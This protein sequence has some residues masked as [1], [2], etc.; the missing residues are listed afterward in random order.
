MHVTLNAGK[1]VYLVDF[2]A[3]CISLAKGTKSAFS[4]FEASFVYF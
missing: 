2:M 4:L 3:D 1:Y